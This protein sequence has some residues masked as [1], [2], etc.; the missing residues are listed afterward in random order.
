MNIGFSYEQNFKCYGLV[1]IF[2]H[3]NFPS[4]DTGIDGDGLHTV[5]TETLLFFAA[6]EGLAS[7]VRLKMSM[8]YSGLIIAPVFYMSADTNSSLS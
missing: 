3:V 4:D 8:I 7:Q 2:V 5:S 1:F 6:Q